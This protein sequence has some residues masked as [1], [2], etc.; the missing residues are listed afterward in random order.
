MALLY[1]VV[2]AIPELSAQVGDVLVL[3]PAGVR[4]VHPLPLDVVAPYLSTDAVT[5][6]F[7]DETVAPATPAPLKERPTHVL[8]L[9]VSTQP[10]PR[11]GRK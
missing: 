8:R 7:A 5:P 1:R 9:E 4:L 11:R 10:G 2:T 3:M 6:E